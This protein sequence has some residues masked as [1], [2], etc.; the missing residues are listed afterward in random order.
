MTAKE[1]DE[2]DVIEAIGLIISPLP[3]RQESMMKSMPAGGGGDPAKREF[4]Y[5]KGS[6]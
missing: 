1:E 4:V 3:L 6:R 2:Q 5:R